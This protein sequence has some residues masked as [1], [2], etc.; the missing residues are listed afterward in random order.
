MLRPYLRLTRF[1]ILGALLLPLI[2][3]LC[4][5]A[6][7]PTPITTRVV[8]LVLAGAIAAALLDAGVTRVFGMAQSAIVRAAAGQAA[9]LD[10]LTERFVPAAIVASAATSLF[11]ELSMIRWQGSVWEFF[12]FYKNFGLLSCFAGLGLGYALAR[13]DHIPLFLSIPMTALQMLLF[14]GL[15][16]GVA[17]R[18][19]ASLLVTP[20]REQLNMGLD[21]ATRAPQYVAIYSFLVVV[22]MLTALAFIPVGQLCG[23]LLGRTTALRAYGL[24]LLGSLAGVLLMLAVSFLWTPPV[25][26]FASAFAVILLFLVYDAR[27]LLTGAVSTF[28]V[29]TILA[30]PVSFR[31]ELVY[32]PYQ[33]LERGYGERG[34]MMIRAAGQYYQ[35]V[36][37]LSP[38]AQAIRPE[39]KPLAAYYELPYVVHP[40]VADVAIVGAG[41][42]NDVAAALRR[43]A[44]HVDAIEIDPA[45][46]ALGAVYHPEAPYGDVRVRRIVDDARSFLRR[47]TSRYDVV[48]YGL[49]D[50]H[51]LLSHASNLRLDSF[52]YTV[53][54]LRE[55]RARLKD[56]GV[57]SL[58]FSVLSD[59]I[60]R[61]IYLMMTAAFDGHPPR[62]VRTLYDAS[63]VCLQSRRGDLVI[64]P[65]LLASLGF[66][67]VTAVYANSTLKADVSTDDWPFFYM[68]Q[69]VYPTSYVY[70]MCLVVL[71]GALLFFSFIPGRPH[72][73]HLGSFLL[74]A[75][76]MLV[77]T[78]NITELGLTFGNTWEVIGIAIAGILA[79][80]FLA[81]L[82]VQ[83]A[84]VQR[85]L[86]PYV[87]LLASLAAG[88]WI[89]TQGGFTSTG[90]GRIAAVI[91]LTSPIFFSGVVFSAMLAG[92][93]DVSAALAM[94]LVGAMVGGML[95]YNSMYFGFRALYL[96]AALFYGTAMLTALVPRKVLPT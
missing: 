44:A 95:E 89:S 71:V 2:V 88:W 38:G 53:E 7:E 62:C 3:A 63:V 24:N 28:V 48:A 23:R 85:P 12:A 83:K 32:S 11:L 94:N 41:S 15:R 6:L 34:L 60:G 69:R 39:L 30:W 75:G 82:W 20:V 90:V 78:K 5:R 18:Y 65:D 80:A 72:V 40:T 93:S 96:V 26:W 21:V 27:V 8:G 87:L 10:Q 52:V 67:E 84:G 64:A 33:L 70:M 35:R 79:M 58:S 74:G 47:T 37:D 29:V 66:T 91:V 22:M 36:H 31:F 1:G 19:S 16:H 42:G 13:R 68:P 45:I 51:T 43:G 54:G 76:F 73:S 50:S 57:L 14:I 61:K 17:A 49:L 59:E 55:G 86:V 92:V 4:S 56:D 9:F 46:M 81:N 77:E 25:V